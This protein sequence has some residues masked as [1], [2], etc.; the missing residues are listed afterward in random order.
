M[1]KM[2]IGY[3]VSQSSA[4]TAYGAA[5]AVL[6]VL[7]WIYYSTLIFF[8]GAEFT[9]SFAEAHGHR[10][11]PKEYAVYRPH[12]ALHHAPVDDSNRAA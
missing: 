6:V 8:L 3:Y 9:Q 11:R 7:A 10:V 2:A 4:N 12:R 5:G 1:G